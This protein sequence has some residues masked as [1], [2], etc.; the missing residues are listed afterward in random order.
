MSILLEQSVLDLFPLSSSKFRAGPYVLEYVLLALLVQSGFLPL[1]R[2]L[3]IQ[4]KVECG[5][6]HLVILVNIFNEGLINWVVALLRYDVVVLLAVV[7]E[8]NAFLEGLYVTSR[9]P[10]SS[11]FRCGTGEAHTAKSLRP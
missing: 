9:Q 10:S 8:V 6:P 3:H 4:S 5:R 1:L 11:K 2:H 7:N